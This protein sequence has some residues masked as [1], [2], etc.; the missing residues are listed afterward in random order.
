M[1]HAH[2]GLAPTGTTQ[3]D[4]TAPLAA[5]P[6]LG[7]AKVSPISQRRPRVAVLFP[8]L[9]TRRYTASLRYYSDLSNGRLEE[10]PM[11][12]NT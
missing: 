11:E 1:V 12:I 10:A 8:P 6:L 3:R 9:P 5:Y 4:Y 7:L 2:G